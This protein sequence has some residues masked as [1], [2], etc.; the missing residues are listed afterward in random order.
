MEDQTEPTHENQ[1]VADV[2]FDDEEQVHP[3][4]SDDHSHE[5]DHSLEK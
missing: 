4:N 2:D 1:P 5:L 3:I